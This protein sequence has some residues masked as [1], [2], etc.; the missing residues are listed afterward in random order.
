M[1]KLI[2]VVVLIMT[3][4]ACSSTRHCDAYGDNTIEDVKETT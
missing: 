2:A 1:K 3:C 4:Y